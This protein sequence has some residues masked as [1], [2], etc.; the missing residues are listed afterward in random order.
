MRY[1]TFDTDKSTNKDLLE[2]GR[3]LR[4]IINTQFSICRGLTVLVM[5]QTGSV[6]ALVSADVIKEND[7]RT[8]LEKIV[9]NAGKK[10]RIRSSMSESEAGLTILKT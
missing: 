1:G 4:N 6:L 5:Q 10:Y 8:V 3:K 7:L 9:D 2:V